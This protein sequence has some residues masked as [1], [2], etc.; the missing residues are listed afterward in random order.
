MIVT[1]KKKKKKTIIKDEIVLLISVHHCATLYQGF[2]LLSVQAH[3]PQLR[4]PPCSMTS[5]GDHCSEANGF[6]ATIFFIALYLVA[7]GS[8]CLKPNM[9]SHGADQFRKDDP[10]HSKKL[11]T[12][13]NTAYFSFCIGELITLTV[14]IWVQTQLG[15]AV[16]FGVSAVTMVMGL[17]SLICGMFYYRNK[18]PEGSIFTPI[19][20]VKPAPLILLP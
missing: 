14:I 18:P 4:P 9:I 2:I 13:F 11:S 5:E 1:G 12:Y 17:T 16:G 3:L 20:R 19:A 15:M 8:G 7:L 10:D 6:K